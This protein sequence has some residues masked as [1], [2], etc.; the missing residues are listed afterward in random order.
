MNNYKIGLN[1]KKNENKNIF[2]LKNMKEKSN[3][4]SFK[5]IILIPSSKKI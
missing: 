4:K 3:L 2:T 1:I 5:V